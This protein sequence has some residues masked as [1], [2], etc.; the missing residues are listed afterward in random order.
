VKQI[1]L[2]KHWLVCCCV[3]GLFCR[4]KEKLPEQYIITPV[5]SSSGSVISTILTKDNE[6]FACRSRFHQSAVGDYDYASLVADSRT[7]GVDLV[8]IGVDNRKFY[9]LIKSLIISP[10]KCCSNSWINGRVFVI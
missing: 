4:R 2:I 5:V 7:D 9:S 6:D 10:E 3:N 8:R 1:Q